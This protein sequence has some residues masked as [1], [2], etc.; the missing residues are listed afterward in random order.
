MV[1]A[2][3]ADTEYVEDWFSDD[4]GSLTPFGRDQAV[5]L[6]QSLST[7][8]IARVW[9]S[10]SSR[11]VQTAELAAGSLGVRVAVRKQL[12]EVGI[13]DLIGSPFD[14]E[15]IRAVTDR[16]AE[17]DL[18]AAFP[19]GE[20]GHDV[21]ARYRDQLQGIADEHRGETVLVIGHESAACAALT[22]MAGNLAPPYDA[23]F[24]RLRNGETVEMMM[25]ADG[26][27]LVR[28]GDLRL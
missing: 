13:G 21:V 23:R 24:G 22:T 11:A 7:Q 4:G 1:F 8:R 20:S 17:G 19:R 26:V 25:D 16:W 2:R 5:A 6:G 10:D 9:S 18:D 14:V 3:H 27:R 28:W 15:K 12:R